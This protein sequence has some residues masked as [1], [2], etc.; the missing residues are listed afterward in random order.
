MKNSQKRLK[1]KT[2]KVKVSFTGGNVSKYGGLSVV[3]KYID[4]QSVTKELNMLF[5]TVYHNA[6]KFSTVQ[7]LMSVILASLCGVNRIRRIAVFTCDALV[8]HQ[9]RLVKG[10]NADAISGILKK[11]GQCG[12]R[13]LEKLL[14]RRHSLW[15]E[16]SGLKQITLDADSTVSL[17]CGNQEGAAKGYSDKKKGAKS[18]HPLLVFVSEI[19]LLYHSWFRTGAAYTSNGIVEF[20]KQVRASLP[21]SVEK[22][23]FRADSGF[24]SGKLLDYLEKM[25]WDYLIK[26][27]LKGLQQLLD[28]Q[29]WL[30]V[31]SKSGASVCD[32]EYKA[33]E[34]GKTRTFRAIRTVKE[35]REVEY[36][37]TKQLVPVYVYACYV[38]NI[39]I[40]AVVLH[41]YYKERSTSETWIEQVKA[42]LMA[43]KTLTDDF[44]ANDILWQ[45][46]VFAYNIST[47][48]RSKHKR[49]KKEEHRTFMEWFIYVPARLVSSANTVELKMHE[50]HFEKQRWLEFEKFAEAP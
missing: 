26:V 25:G 37:G 39:E 12:A 18:Y 11:L 1:N 30:P 17:V 28:K 7:V 34:W 27:K 23:F 2:A 4:R 47:M 3:A 8:K 24:F 5:P 48:M 42:Q 33:K 50:H 20:L 22:V 38:S 29:V 9:L 13:R 15:P 49:I 10:I 16:K 44:W 43:G 31:T 40:D 19:K 6:T 14:L 41:D 45:L 35:Y 21:G 32:F 46:Q 36:L